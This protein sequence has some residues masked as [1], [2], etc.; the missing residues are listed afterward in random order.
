MNKSET[1]NARPVM[2]PEPNKP[3]AG[4]AGFAS[5]LAIG[6]HWRGVPEPEHW[7]MS[8][9]RGSTLTP[10]ETPTEKSSAEKRHEEVV[11]VRG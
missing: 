9:V 4:N 2:N 10:K 1:N 6:R 3:A 5:R 8:H 11:H 7:A